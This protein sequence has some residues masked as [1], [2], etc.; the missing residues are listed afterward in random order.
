M[1]IR[2]AEE[3]DLSRIAEIEIFNYRINFYPIFK[4][5]GYYFGELQVSAF[6]ASY[7][8]ELESLYVY[9]DGTVKG[10]IKVEGNELKKLFVEPVLQDKGIGTELL[11]YAVSKLGA[12]NLWV[13]EKN[14]RARQ[15]Y[16]RNGFLATG[17]RKP[18]DD[19]DEWLLYLELADIG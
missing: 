6:M 2:R 1:S 15:F 11:R 10:F 19:T 16:R 8:G 3:K 14:M 12:T 18:V 17:E 7:A 4:N 9:D 13:L 5:D